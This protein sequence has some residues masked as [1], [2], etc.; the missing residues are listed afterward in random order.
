MRVYR[1]KDYKDMMFIFKQVQMNMEKIHMCGL[2][3]LIA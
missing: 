3:Y 1:A 2:V